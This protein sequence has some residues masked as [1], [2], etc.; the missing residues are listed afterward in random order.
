MR[1]FIVV[2]HLVSGYGWFT[3]FEPVCISQSLFFFLSPI[4]ISFFFK[5]YL[6]RVHIM[7]SL[8]NSF[9][10]TFVSRKVHSRA[11][12]SVFLGCL[13]KWGFQNVFYLWI[14]KWDIEINKLN[15]VMDLCMLKFHIILS[16]SN[17]AFNSLFMN[18]HQFW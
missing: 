1:P 15:K 17:F 11:I 18:I 5:A 6:Y 9:S 2:Y 7:F 16:Y 8:I 14:F 12:L 10:L 4:T 3:I 13:I